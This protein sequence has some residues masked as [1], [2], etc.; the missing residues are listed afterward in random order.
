M[1]E[2]LVPC[3]W[4]NGV[5]IRTK[6]HRQWDEKV[7]AITKGLTIFKPGKGQWVN[8]QGDLYIDRIIPVRVAATAEQMQEI[9]KITIRHYSQEAVMYYLVSE[10]LVLEFATP[11]DREK[12]HR[13]I[14]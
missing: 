14:R 8:L 1:W 4:N 10:K 7:R 5:P 12:F 2:I 13:K 11:K 6:H 9:A 3:N